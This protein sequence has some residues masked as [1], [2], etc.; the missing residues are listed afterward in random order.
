MA[1]RNLTLLFA[2]P[3][4]KFILRSPWHSMASNEVMLITVTGRKSGKR[5]TTPVNY[6]Q[7][8]D[9]LAV[10]SHSHRTWWRNLRGGAPV[11]VVLRGKTEKATAYAYDTPD[12]V[13]ERFYEHLQ[14]APKYAEIFNVELDEEGQPILAS[15]AAAA[16]GKVMVDVWLDEWEGEIT[17]ADDENHHTVDNA[18]GNIE[19]ADSAR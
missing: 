18:D 7:D 2:N 6:I 15:A 13:V 4:M 19:D 16:A 14:A 10:L 1:K 11:M 8:E 9:L 17:E 5:Y 12:E 3:V